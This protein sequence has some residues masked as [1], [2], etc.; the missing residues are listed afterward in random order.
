MLNLFY[1]LLLNKTNAI[2]IQYFIKNKLQY[3]YINYKFYIYKGKGLAAIS[4]KRLYSSSISLSTIKADGCKEAYA[5]TMIY[6]NRGL[7]Q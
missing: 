4:S 3:I 2:L 5:R 6:S 7:A 1:Y